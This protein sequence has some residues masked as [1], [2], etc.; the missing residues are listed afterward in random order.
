MSILEGVSQTSLQIDADMAPFQENARVSQLAARLG[1]SDVTLKVTRALSLNAMYV[2]GTIYVGQAML[3]E[4]DTTL[5]FAIAHEY[6]HHVLTHWRVNLLRGVVA[7]AKDNEES[8]YNSVVVNSL[9]T[10]TPAASQDRERAADVF[11]TTLLSKAGMY[12]EAAIK[13]IFSKLEDS[14]THPDAQSRINGALDARKAWL[15]QI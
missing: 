6:G 5:A 8:S 13:A 15:A 1:I 10:D 11:A 4:D 3:L 14:D 9:V 7:S 12:N 2:P